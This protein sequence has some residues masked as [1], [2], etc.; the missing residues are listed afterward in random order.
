MDQ[1]HI[2][3]LLRKLNCRPIKPSGGWVYSSC[4]LA[5]Y[6]HAKGRDNHPSFSVAISAKGI[7]GA[8]CHACNF[9]GSLLELLWKLE[10]VS[11]RSW[12]A[13]ADF[14][15]KHN[16]IDHEAAAKTAS[17]AE[18]QKRRMAMVAA[19]RPIATT[20]AAASTEV[21]K[22]EVAG[23][24]GVQLSLIN[25]E[26]KLVTLEDKMLD[27]YRS[28]PTDVKR[29]L[30]DDRKMD[31]EMLQRWEVGWDARWRRIVIPVRDCKG[32]LVGIS[33][34]AFNPNDKPKYMHS[35][36][37]RRDFYIY[38]E[39]FLQEGQDVT[40]YIT[41]GFFDVM[42]LRSRGYRGIAV[43]GT[44]LSDFQ[45]EKLVRFFTKLVIV[46][47]GDKPGYEAAQRMFEQLKTRLPTSVA[48]IPEGMDPDDLSPQ[49]M[50]QQFGPPD[51]EVR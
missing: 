20:P 31:P 15:R 43:M 26:V 38:G 10:A 12:G 25:S 46:P 5:P 4:P 13:L 33:R 29:Y 23:I 47:D 16:Q 7:S 11:H 36:G 6:T 8:R 48:D 49:Q 50:F 9:S 17:Y 41:E 18:V 2:E 24:S 51:P 34:R 22:E 27:Q 35:A 45:A 14:V 21:S 19:S 37:F 30:L 44:H 1:P 42:R 40:G 32:R 3:E 39:C 28:V